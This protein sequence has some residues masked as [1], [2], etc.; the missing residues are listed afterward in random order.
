MI[1]IP[2]LFCFLIKNGQFWGFRSISRVAQA[3]LTTFVKVESYL[4]GPYGNGKDHTGATI[5]GEQ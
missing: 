2:R 4:Q 1:R 3:A 5:V